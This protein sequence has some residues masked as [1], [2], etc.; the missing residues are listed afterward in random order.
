MYGHESVG[1]GLA[2]SEIVEFKPSLPIRSEN[3]LDF[4]L[5]FGWQSGIH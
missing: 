1:A 2:G 5:F 3:L 4:D